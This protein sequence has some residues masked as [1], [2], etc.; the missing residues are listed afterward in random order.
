[1]TRMTTV[2]SI[3]SQLTA[4]R[5]AGT[6]PSEAAPMV[7]ELDG[8]SA[9]MSNDLSVSCQCSAPSVEA[10]GLCHSRPH[11]QEMGTT[12]FAVQ[13]DALTWDAAVRLVTNPL[14]LKQ[15]MILPG[16]SS[17]F[18]AFLLTVS[19]AM[20]GDCDAVSA[21]PAHRHCQHCGHPAHPGAT[22]CRHAGSSGARRPSRTAR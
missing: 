22:L 18:T 20:V 13:G 17:L 21:V 6:G 4:A 11:G 19:S 15:L 8:R 12:A 7:H 9:T 1:M 10:S 3:H 5:A 2:R 16:G 14:V